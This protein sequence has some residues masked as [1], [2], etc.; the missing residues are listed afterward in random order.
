MQKG[1]ENAQTACVEEIAVVGED[2]DCGQQGPD[3]ARGEETKG[4]GG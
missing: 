1:R 3:A 2:V 4:F